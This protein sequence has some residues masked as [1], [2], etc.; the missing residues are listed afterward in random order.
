MN[1]I[2][3]SPL[4]TLGYHFIPAEYLPAGK[5]EYHIRHQ[6]SNNQIHYRH[7]TAWEIE[8]LVRNR[9]T[10]DDWNNLLVSDA[11]NPEL[12]QNC[13]FYGL[14]R[15]GKLESVYLEFHNL[16]RPVGLYN[17]TVISCDFGDNIVVDNVNY[18][19]HYITGNDVML[20]NINEIATT[21]HAKFGNGILKDG[22]SENIRIWLEAC[23]E[24]GGRSIIPFDGMLPGDAYLWTRF[25]DDDQFQQKL[26]DFTQARFDTRRGYYGTIGDRTVIKNCRIVKDVNIGSDAYLKGANKIKN[27]TINSSA[28][29]KSQVGEGCELVNGIVD[30][31]C[32]LFYGVKAVRFFMASHSQL[33]YGAR[34]INS[35]LGNNSTIS[36]CEVL[37]S[38][39]FPGHEQHHNNSFLCAALV[40]GQSNMAAGATIGSNH[41]SR[42][43]DGELIAGRGFWPGLCVSLKHNSQFASFSILAK[44]DYPAELNIPIPFA[45][46]SN[47]VTNN[48]LLV[49]PAYWFLYN[50]YAL[51][52]NAW[53]YGDRDKRTQKIQ[54]LENNY[55]APDTINEI[56]HSLELMQELT[57]KAWLRHQQQERKRASREELMAIGKQLLDSQ[58]P[59]LQELEIQ[60]EG[61]EN[62]RRPVVLLKVPAAYQIFRELITYYAVQQLIVQADTYEWKTLEQVRAAVPTR[63]SLD[64]WTNVGGQLIR[65]VAIEKLIQKIHTGRVKSWEQ[66]HAFYTEQADAYAQEKFQHAAA[67][68]QAVH[69][70]H[71]RKA[72]ADSIKSLL[73]QS[74][75]TR[76]WMVKGI[77]EAR[78]KDYKNPF[79]KMVYESTAAMNKVT[80]KL[81]QNAFIKQEKE[82]LETFRKT[83]ASLSR[84]WAGK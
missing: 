62:N 32:R 9:N 21:D 75:Q 50:M 29:A 70:I 44:G 12:V 53:K 69:G 34:L 5:D 63:L 72:G 6:Q 65:Q 43:P 83:I 31:G 82:G 16:R 7:L 37:N 41:N 11:F 39:I 64:T 61:F 38:L 59:I 33:K 30:Y 20:V 51:A 48:R 36:C 15:I 74:L 68:L 4:Q 71:L 73:D 67:A 27:V 47:D 24:N 13:K 55:L 66:V 81:E 1:Q 46:T 76:E 10:S 45:L 56:V 57:G 60:A 78:A 79:R 49:M 84:K 2:R 18:I 52:R 42:S 54:L 26:K 80:G 23:N 35:Y 8:M 28:K 58:D 3:K 17:S 22:E 77:Y 14:V 40:Q 19:S 25:R